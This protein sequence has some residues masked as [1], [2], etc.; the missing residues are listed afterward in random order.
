VPSA[1]APSI[2]L[3]KSTD[4]GATFGTATVVT[5][6]AVP[7]GIDV[8]G[9][10]LLQGRF[11]VNPGPSL[12]VDNTT[13]KPTSGSVYISWAEGTNMFENVF[14]LDEYSFSDVKLARSTDGGGTFGAPVRVNS[15]V[16][17]IPAPSLLAGRGTDQWSPAM[18][19]E[20]KTGA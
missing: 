12:V 16:E 6:L 7:G 15:S 19:V 14:G 4:G 5:P 18:A 11:R 20:A 2:Q 3:K 10:L 17:P 8:T 1:A 13:G 9:E